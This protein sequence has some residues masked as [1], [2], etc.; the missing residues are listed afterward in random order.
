MVR[1]F[2]QRHGWRQLDLARKAGVG[3]SVISDVEL[4]RLNGRTIAT[5]RAILGVFGL[6]VEMGVRGV[7]ADSDRVLDA[8][9]S[10]LLGTCAKW[11]EDLGWKTA[12]EVTFA[13]W[14]E[15]GSVDL[16]AWHPPTRTL[17][18]VE[19]KTELASVEE[20]LRKHGTKMRLGA[21]IARPLGW[22]P[23]AVGRLLVLPEDRTQRR[24]VLANEPVMR[25]AYPERSHAV[26]A[27]CREPVGGLSGLIF[28]TDSA[29][30]GRMVGRARRERVRAQ[31]TL[32]PEHD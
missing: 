5:L 1:V 27:W 12:P 18:V 6:S 32:Q 29:R 2:R 9:H 16:L 24:R 26:K 10:D 20:T 13:E 22:S 30:S 21:V 28:L 8:R 7:G 11:L 31:R 14:G 19:I 23:S 15:R 3:R 17:L 4:G 25:R